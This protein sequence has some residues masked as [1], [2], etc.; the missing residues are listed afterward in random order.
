MPRIA[1]I[2]DIHANNQALSQVLKDIEKRN[3]DEIIC[4]GDLVAKYYYPAEV[5]DAIRRNCKM[6][7]QGNCDELYASNIEN[8]IFEF[9]RNKL[10]T[11]RL[12]YL[13]HIPKNAQMENNDI[14]TDLFHAAPQNIEAMFNPLANNEKTK[15]KN[16]IVRNPQEMFISQS[17]NLSLVGHTHQ[18]FIGV[19]KEKDFSLIKGNQVHVSKEDKVIIN[20]GSVGE[21]N[22]VVRNEH[23]EQSFYISPYITYAIMEYNNQKEGIDVEIIKLDYKDTLRAVYFD[24][25]NSHNIGTAPSSTNQV[26]KVLKSIHFNNVEISEEP[27]IRKS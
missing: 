6:V 18:H 24:M 7:I 1:I 26:S 9:T 13:R 22:T 14:L 8:S 10:G 15:Y 11:D 27:K 5:V 25:V 3:V 2:S 20:V 4:L 12:E 23:G 19:I 21:H 17:S 16:L